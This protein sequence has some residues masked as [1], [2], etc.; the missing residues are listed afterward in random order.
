MK[1][2]QQSAFDTDGDQIS[3]QHSVLVVIKSMKKRQHS[4]FGTDVIQHSEFGT[5]GDQIN[6][7][8]PA[9]SI[10]Y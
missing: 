4:A 9:L 8:T 6:E 1:K 5:C 3:S 10:R 7:E 2:R